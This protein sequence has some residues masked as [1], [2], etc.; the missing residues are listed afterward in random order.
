MFRSLAVLCL[1]LVF[2]VETH[3]G[4]LP[5]QVM[6]VWFQRGLV[7]WFPSPAVV[8]ATFPV[9]QFSQPVQTIWTFMHICR[10]MGPACRLS[11]AWKLLALMSPYFY[12]ALCC[13]F[14]FFIRHTRHI[15]RINN[16]ANDSHEKQSWF[17]PMVCVCVCVA[18]WNLGVCFWFAARECRHVHSFTVWEKWTF[19]KIQSCVCSWFEAKRILSTSHI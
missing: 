1:C 17:S 13:F 10:L 14:V 11:P 15:M 8:S 18:K 2:L 12:F 7:K 19:S 4:F 9:P 6:E 5:E 16:C 3:Q